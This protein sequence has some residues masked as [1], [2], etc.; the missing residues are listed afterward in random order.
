MGGQIHLDG[1][2][3]GVVADLHLF[4]G[5]YKQSFRENVGVSVG[6]Y[7]VSDVNLGMLGDGFEVRHFRVVVL[8]DDGAV[9]VGGRDHRADTGFR[10]QD[11][12]D[13][14]KVRRHVRHH[15][16]HA[17]RRQHCHVA[18]DAVF[19]TFID[20]HVVEGAIDSPEDDVCIGVVV[21]AHLSAVRGVRLAHL[22]E[23]GVLLLNEHV[24]MLTHQLDVLLHQR[25]VLRSQTETVYHTRAA[26]L[27]R[28]H[29]ALYGP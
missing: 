9:L 14:G 23:E 1:E 17:G 26:L 11:R 18:G 10:V 5:A 29:N 4:H 16:C 8:P 2:E 20:Y 6:E 15:A 25:L 13:C 12:A 3:A 24:L 27:N 21:E 28:S 7:G 19:G 22:C